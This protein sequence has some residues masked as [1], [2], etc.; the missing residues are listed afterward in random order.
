MKVLPISSN[1]YY[2]KSFKAEINETPNMNEPDSNI[3]PA[4]SAEIKED[5]LASSS[6]KINTKDILLGVGILAS[7][8]VAGVALYKNKNF[9]KEIGEVND[10]LKKAEKKAE[11]LQTKLQ[12]AE[13]KIVAKA[14]KVQE[15]V[16]KEVPENIESETFASLKKQNDDLKKENNSLRSRINQ[17]ECN[18]A[19]GK[20]KAKTNTE[21]EADSSGVGKKNKHFFVPRL[22]LL[23]STPKQ[24]AEQR[25]KAPVSPKAQPN[26]EIVVPSTSSNPQIISQN[27]VVD[28]DNL[29]NKDRKNIIKRLKKRMAQQIA[30]AKKKAKEPLNIKEE[31][32]EIALPF[33]KKRI[34]DINELKQ[35]TKK[36]S[37]KK[38][39]PKIRSF[40]NKIV[41]KYYEIKA[42]YKYKKAQNL[43]KN[44]SFNQ[45][46]QYRKAVI[47]SDRR[48]EQW[49][50]RQHK[51]KEKE[52][53][54]LFKNMPT[55][56]I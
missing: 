24:K 29:S 30:R 21:T 26:T 1:V 3:L 55:K 25:L 51:I 54:R 33:P 31:Q 40:F 20:K 42:D 39:L 50:E 52:Y 16:K 14:D 5:T 28:F 9:K 12:D 49:L 19:E 18:N 32:K 10:K 48:N 45:E 38:I 43:L 34:I 11:D 13:A 37:D 15:Q 41:L 56:V 35:N 7:L 6:R 46:D 53:N 23:K 47:A 36:K 44:E 22:T 4:E 17:K 2:N 8:T 27:D